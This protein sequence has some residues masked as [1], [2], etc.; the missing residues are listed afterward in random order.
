MVGKS[1]V[2]ICELRRL[3]NTSARLNRFSATSSF[4]SPGPHHH[5]RAPTS[6]LKRHSMHSNNSKQR[7][8]LQTTPPGICSQFMMIDAAV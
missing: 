4:G 2:W 3:A 1:T 6:S 5:A 8:P 7:F